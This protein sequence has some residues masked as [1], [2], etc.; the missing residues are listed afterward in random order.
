MSLT[1]YGNDGHS[2]IS[3][4]SFNLGVLVT[5]MPFSF[6]RGLMNPLRRFRV[7][8]G[9]LLAA[10]PVA[11]LM[12]DQLRLASRELQTTVWRPREP[13]PAFF[14]TWPNAI[15]CVSMM[16]CYRFPPPCATRRTISRRF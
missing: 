6:C 16:A 5:V 9:L 4:T 11:A 7:V 1:L 13:S 14:S 15:W 10:L 2:R 12:Q 8:F 3:L